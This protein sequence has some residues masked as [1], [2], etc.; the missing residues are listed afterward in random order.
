MERVMLI[1]EYGELLQDLRPHLQSSYYQVVELQS[2]NARTFNYKDFPF[3]QA[4]VVV[5]ANQTRFLAMVESELISRIL[6]DL[7]RIFLKNKL[8]N[9]SGIICIGNSNRGE[10]SM[11]KHLFPYYKARR[12]Q[13]CTKDDFIP[14]LRHMM[15][16]SK[17]ESSPSFWPYIYLGIFLLALLLSVFRY[18]RA[19][20]QTA[21]LQVLG[22]QGNFYYYQTEWGLWKSEKISEQ[23][24]LSCNNKLEDSMSVTFQLLQE[25]SDELKGCQH[26]NVELEE[27]IQLL[28]DELERLK[29]ELEFQRRLR[30]VNT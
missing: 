22:S 4:F 26:R 23:L 9:K 11:Q 17:I 2:F 27:Q 10:R 13:H 6:R 30:I 15:R 3:T 14:T 12:F 8:E 1:Q 29:L 7:N 21:N 25:E 5:Q 16:Q 18:S 20:H 19:F 28:H 24:I